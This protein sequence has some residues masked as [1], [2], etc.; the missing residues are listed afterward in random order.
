MAQAKAW[1]R[2][3]V[4]PGRGS[5]NDIRRKRL[6]HRDTQSGVTSPSES[7]HH[8]TDATHDVDAIYEHIYDRNTLGLPGYGTQNREHQDQPVALQSPAT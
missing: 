8:P 7:I 2:T 5:K 1:T 3:A 6:R 4:T